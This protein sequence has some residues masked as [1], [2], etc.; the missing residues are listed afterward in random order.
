M[1]L[2]ARLGVLCLVA[3]A[4]SGCTRGDEPL[5]SERLSQMTRGEKLAQLR[6]DQRDPLGEMTLGPEGLGSLTDPYARLPVEDAVRSS[7]RLQALVREKTRLGIPILV[8]AEGVHGLVARD[9]TM[10]PHAIALASTFDPALVEQIAGVVAVEARARGIGQILAPVVNVARDPRWGRVQETYGED[11]LVVSRLGAAFCRGLEHGGVVATPKH[12]LAN[13]G[14]GGRDS[15]AVWLSERALRETYLPPFEACIR[16]GG[17]GSV[18]AALNSIDGVPCV[19][20]AWLLDRVLR[21]EWGFEG[22]VVADYAALQQ[23]LGHGTAASLE[24]VAAQALAAGLDVDLPSGTVYGQPL[25]QALRDGRVADAALDAAVRRVLRIKAR[26]GVLGPA[27]APPAPGPDLVGRREHRWLALSAARE[28]LVLLK[29]DGLLPLSTDVRRIAVLGPGADDPMLGDYSW[30]TPGRPVTVLQ[31]IQARHGG[32]VDHRPGCGLAGLEPLEPLRAPG[33]RADYFAER[34]DGRVLLTRVEP[35]VRLDPA[36]ASLTPDLRQ[37]LAA[38]RWTARLRGPA[39]GTYALSIR[40]TGGT[41]RVRLDGRLLIDEGLPPSHGTTVVV[42]LHVD[43]DRERDLTVELFVA[44]GKGEPRLAVFSDL[45]NPQRLAEAV[46]AARAA[47]VAVVVVVGLEGEGWDRSSLDLPGAQAQLI[48]AVAA[49]GKPTV[50]VI[51]AGAP[52]T[53][54]SW[55]DAVGAILLPWY[56]GEQGGTAVA[57]ALFGDFS[58]SG[59][60]PI[61]F[62]QTVGQSP[63]TYDPAPSGRSLHYL[64][65]AGPQFAFGHGLGY[66]RFEYSG[67]QIEPA[68]ISP[69]GTALVRAT[70]RNVGQRAADEVVQLYLRQRV[71]SVA[72]PLLALKGFERVRLRPG[73]ARPVTFQVG[74][75]ELSLLDRGLKRVVEPGRFDIEIGAASDD[76]RLEGELTVGK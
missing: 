70:V 8:H 61:T 2:S 75:A 69:S 36:D 23:V 35:E 50:V 19:T 20:N 58:P 22:F 41:M 10:F 63:L 12:L 76:I 33:I 5:V 68:V 74:P 38:V 44:K 14:D 62:P 34:L 65:A 25:E 46:A 24:D 51:A 17:A 29:N 59:R 30:L 48:A 55:V 43:A 4:W 32:T 18:M 67:L 13:Y 3:L 57:Q 71:A 15:N 16:E 28:G 7:Q 72:R 11:P 6:C 27:P 47:D 60:L 37:Q 52:I 66:S 54:G 21:R 56:A 42:P 1:S 39:T 53:M 45:P 49:T 64:D 40:Y 73:E 26:H 31:G 9:A